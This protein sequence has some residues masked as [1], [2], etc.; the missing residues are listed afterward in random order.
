MSAGSGEEVEGFLEMQCP[1][2]PVGGTARPTRNLFVLQKPQPS[3]EMQSP[4]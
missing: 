2:L 3:R 4:L 1:L